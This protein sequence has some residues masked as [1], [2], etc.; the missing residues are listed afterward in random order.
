MTRDTRI[1]LFLMRELTGAIRK[2]DSDAF[3][4]LMPGGF[5]Q[6]G[7]EIVVRIYLD[8][9]GAFLAVDLLCRICF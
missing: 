1:A 3:N 7:G 5:Q 2:N 9:L 8:R 6:L 4:C